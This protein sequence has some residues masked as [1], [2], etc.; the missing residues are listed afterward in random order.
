MAIGFE[1]NRGTRR[2]RFSSNVSHEGVE[3]GPDYP[4]HECELDARS[5][6]GYVREGRAAYVGDDTSPEIETFAELPAKP[7]KGIRK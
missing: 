3:Y 1:T 4:V 7:G 2:V 6:A 5:A